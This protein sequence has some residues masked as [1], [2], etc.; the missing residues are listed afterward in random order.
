M[1][2]HSEHTASRPGS[3]EDEG[4]LSLSALSFHYNGDKQPVLQNL[5]LQFP[6]RAIT[7]IL[8]PNGSG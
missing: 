1:T 6:A 8:G 5:S 7:A 4:I 2:S 3:S